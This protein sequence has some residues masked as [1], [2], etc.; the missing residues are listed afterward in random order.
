[1]NKT[2]AVIDYGMGNLHSVASAVSHVAPD[3][4]VLVTANEADILAADHVIFPGVGAIRDCMAEIRRLQLDST[5]KKVIEQG[6]PLLGVCV[7]M[8]ALMT[9][10]EENGG[11]D[12]L[13][14][15]SGEV[16]LFK[17]EA[18]EREH[19][20][21]PHMGWNNVKTVVDHPLWQGIA[22]NT[23][24]YFVH[25]YY[26]DLHN[27][28]VIGECEYGVPFAAMVA[29]KNVAAVQ[30]HPEKSDTAGLRLI[31]NFLHWDGL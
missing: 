8:Q 31:R 9:H 11:V 7:G 12:C 29:R 22:T 13:D 5:V 30:F 20:K 25:S 27:D 28:L 3:V 1:M 14:V 4:N 2:V 18:V 19:L 26:V 15:F 17:G 6:Q 10:S 16:K 24:F 23:R 21:V